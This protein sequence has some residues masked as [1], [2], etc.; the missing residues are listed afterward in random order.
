[1]ANR[2]PHGK[3]PIGAG[4]GKMDFK[5]LNRLMEDK[6]ADPQKALKEFL[7]HTPLEV[8]AG[9]ALGILIAFL[10]PLH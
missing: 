9:A 2:V 3:A 7:G 8:F 5:V 1:M 10:M 4:R 6:H